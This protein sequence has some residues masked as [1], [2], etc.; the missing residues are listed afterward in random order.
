[1][2]HLEKYNATATLLPSD[3]VADIHVMIIAIQGPEASYMLQPK[4]LQSREKA[5]TLGITGGKE[6]L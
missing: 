1:M 2:T 5:P 4:Q 3:L 6:L